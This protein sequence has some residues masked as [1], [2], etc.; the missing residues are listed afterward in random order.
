MCLG[1]GEWVTHQP[2]WSTI[3]EL[4]TSQGQLP[5]DGYLQQFKPHSTPY[6]IPAKLLLA[7]GQYAVPI[8]VHRASQ[9]SNKIRS[10]F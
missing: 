8:H 2:V 6:H 5:T 7:S 1:V 9:A 4:R 3:V 10:V